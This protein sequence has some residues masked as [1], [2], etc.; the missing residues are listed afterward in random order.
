[1]EKLHGASLQA[2]GVCHA[3]AVPIGG[4]ATALALTEGVAPAVLFGL[5][6]WIS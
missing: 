4:L 6:A 5:A 1:M 3:M 2:I